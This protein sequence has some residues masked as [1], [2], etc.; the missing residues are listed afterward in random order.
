MTL[1]L[2]GFHGAS[3][4]RAA[5]GSL[6]VGLVWLLAAI[7]TAPAL[8]QTDIETVLYN[9]DMTT[10]GEPY[11]SLL[12]DPAGNLYGTALEGGTHGQ[13]VVYELDTAGNYTVLHTFT[14]GADGGEPQAGVIRDAAANLY[15]TTSSG[16]TAGGGT[17]FK[18]DTSGNETV[19]YNFTGGADGG[20]PSAGVIRDA[21]GNLY[22][23]TF[24]GGGSHSNAGVVFKVDP[25]GLETVLHT[26]TGGA[27]GGRPAAGVVRDPAGNL[28][29]TAEWGG[30]GGHGVV[31]KLDT[32]GREKVLHNFTGGADG[33]D[34][35]AGVIRDPDGNLYG[36]TNK[37]G[38][39]GGRGVVYKVDA[40]G[41]QTVLLSFGG[42][43]SGYYPIA[44]V[45]RDQAGN[46]FGTTLWGGPQW[47]GYGV[48]FKLDMSGQE[49]V[50]YSFAA[51]GANPNGGVIA[52]TDGDL[53]GTAGGG[54][55]GFGVVFELKPQ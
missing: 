10:G 20:S 8:A 35:I 7:G 39:N 22:G 33:G 31:Y 1:R 49:T 30:A 12:R 21:A 45:I 11:G 24:F 37:G 6:R 44:G 2:C 17:V 46:L 42:G 36:T 52:G 54:T 3:R 48:V 53:Y 19:L 26:F 32:A 55:Y 13:G 43:S 40:A 23:T 50:L 51:D 25:S 38:T 28:Y 15:G 9:F 27:D 29:G 47:G 16:G 18:L 4:P 14:G 34:P 5:C 41:Q